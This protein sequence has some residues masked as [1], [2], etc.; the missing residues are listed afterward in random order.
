MPDNHTRQ[1]VS[2]A[3]L[4]RRTD[5]TLGSRPTFI[6]GRP[7]RNNGQPARGARYLPF[8]HQ[9]RWG[10]SRPAGAATAQYQG[11]DRR[12]EF[13]VRVQWVG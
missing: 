5:R 3:A 10:A 4:A 12:G 6:G 13:Q 7:A 2:R 11:I 9:L 1:M 8:G